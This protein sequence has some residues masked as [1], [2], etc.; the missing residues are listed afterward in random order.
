MKRKTITKKKTVKKTKKIPDTHIIIVLDESGSMGVQ[1]TETIQGFNTFMEEQRKVKGKADVTL[2][3]FNSDINVLYEKKNIKDVEDLTEKTYEP[4]TLTALND[5]FAKGIEAGDKQTGKNSR[6]LML[7]MTDGGENASQDHKTEQIKKLVEERNKKNNWSFVFLGANIDSFAV[8]GAYGVH[9]GNIA[10]YNQHQ[11]Q[12][13]IRAVSC[14]TAM[15][16]KSVETKTS[17]F[18]N[19]KKNV[20]SK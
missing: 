15:Y 20:T 10:Q 5:A 2:I 17:G 3:K 12:S 14:S 16:R 4:S 13:A 18:F 6:I 19:G 9:A 1:R 8:G 7:V 11:T